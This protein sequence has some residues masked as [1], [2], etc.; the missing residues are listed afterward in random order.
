MHITNGTLQLHVAEDG[1]PALPPILLLHGITAFGGT[2][3]W[4]TPTLAER[5]HVLRLDFRGHGESDRAPDAYTSSGYVS[6]AVA[7]LQ[8]LAGRPCPVIGHSLGGATAAALTQR[9]ADLVTA[10]IL[11]DP[12]LAFPRPGSADG[13]PLEGNSL[14]DGFRLMRQSIPPLQ[15]SKVPLDVLIGI[16]SAAP[17][18]TG[19]STFGEK[20]EADGIAAMARSLMLVDATV[21]DPVVDFSMEPFLDAEAPLGVPTLIVTADP[22][23]PDAVAD[24]VLARRFAEMSKDVEVR[25][26]D[27]AGHL[28]H[29]EKASRP[30]FKSAVIDFLDR[31]SIS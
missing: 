5:F 3:D 13:N 29:D 1:D 21:L 15:E 30:I 25:T 4:L 14:L 31:W 11:E 28:I 9:H 2:W 18:T 27:G 7:V 12:P 26:V 20:L 19:S 6:D 16:L 22:S 24:P 17:D 23:S 10:A 8:Q